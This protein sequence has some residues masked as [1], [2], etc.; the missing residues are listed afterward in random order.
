MIWVNTTG[1][2][3]CYTS[4]LMTCQLPPLTKHMNDNSIANNIH[5]SLRDN[6]HV[7][8]PAS[9]LHPEMT[10]KQGKVKAR[11]SRLAA[12]NG[13]GTGHYVEKNTF[14]YCT[15]RKHNVIIRCKSLVGS[16]SIL[17][18][19]FKARALVPSGENQSQEN[20]QQGSCA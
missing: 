10:M 12:M 16:K 9:F 5:C 13:S 15:W 20:R 19:L 1:M 4:L 17:A 11:E 8:K 18:T 14:C 7:R 6:V 2:R 3:C